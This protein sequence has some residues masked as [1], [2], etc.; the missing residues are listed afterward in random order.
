M[1]TPG[2]RMGIGSIIGFLL[3]AI[4][5]YWLGVLVGLFPELSK[6]VAVSF[7]II[8]VAVGSKFTGWY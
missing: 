3:L 4:A 7:L 1:A 8:F 2:P 5:L 6:A